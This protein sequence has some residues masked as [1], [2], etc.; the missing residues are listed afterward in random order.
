MT[1]SAVPLITEIL[2]RYCLPH[3]TDN[4]NDTHVTDA[5]ITGL[6]CC[7]Y[8]TDGLVQEKRNSSAL[9]MELRLS[10]TSPSKWTIILVGNDESPY[11]DI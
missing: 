11:L 7:S 6:G 8:Q 9:A 5:A 1:F 3:I 2:S 4:Q 10:C